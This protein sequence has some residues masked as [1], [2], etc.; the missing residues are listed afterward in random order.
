MLS[1][2][3]DKNHILFGGTKIL[4][5]TADKVYSAVMTDICFQYVLPL[6]YMFTSIQSVNLQAPDGGCVAFVLRTGF[7]TSQGKLMRTI[8]FSTERVIYSSSVKELNCLN[9]YRCDTH[10]L[11]T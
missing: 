2:K 8:L 6:P 5:H 10:S 9:A 4:Q 11:L 3:R 1:V 7:E